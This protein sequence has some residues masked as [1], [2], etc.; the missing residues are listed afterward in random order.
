MQRE[1]KFRIS[2][3]VFVYRELKGHIV[4]RIPAHRSRFSACASHADRSAGG[5]HIMFIFLFAIYDI[6][7][8]ICDLVRV[9]SD[10][11]HGHASRL[12]RQVHCYFR[13]SS[14]SFNVG[15]RGCPL[16]AFQTL[17]SPVLTIP[18]SAALLSVQVLSSTIAQLSGKR[19]VLS[20]LRW[21]S[22]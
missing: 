21:S 8:K 9:L 7:Y 12:F 2:V 17:T 4:V 11:L 3:S 6:R 5:S 15:K 22:S 14:T 16:L 20:L 19:T 10:Y 18:A 1:T 13:Y